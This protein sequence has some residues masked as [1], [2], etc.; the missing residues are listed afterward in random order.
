VETLKY[1]ADNTPN[2]THQAYCWEY[3]QA[4]NYGQGRIRELVLFAIIKSEDELCLDNKSQPMMCVA[5]CNS[6]KGISGKAKINKL[7]RALLTPKHGISKIQSYKTL[8]D[9]DEFCFGKGKPYTIKVEN[10]TVNGKRVSNITHV[11]SVI[12]KQWMDIRGVFD[13]PSFIK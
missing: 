5:V 10:K 9:M 13:S 2:G 6:T 3:L 1:Y 11:Y 8:P 7:K 12:T 4:V